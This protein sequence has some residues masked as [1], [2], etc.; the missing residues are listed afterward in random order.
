MKPK[1]RALIIGLDGATWR[2][3]TRLIRKGQLQTLK[4][5]VE[6][7]TSGNLQSTI[8]PWTIP[9][10]E[11]M[12][13][14]LNPGKIGFA[15]FTIRKG[16]NFIPYYFDHKV[17]HKN[18]WDMLSKNDKTVIV[19]NVP[20]IYSAYPING[21]MI[22]GFLTID[23][24][25]LTYPPSL[26]EKLNKV[27]GEYIP[28]IT[29]VMDLTLGDPQK[30]YQKEL[31]I[32]NIHH[33]TFTYLLLEYQ[34]DFGFIVYAEPDRVQHKFWG[35]WDRIKEIYRRLD[36]YLY[37]MLENVVT[38]DTVVFIVSDHGF[39]P[40]D[41]KILWINK[42]LMERGYLVLKRNI[43]RQILLRLLWVI[44]KLR[45]DKTVMAT[46][47]K[48]PPSVHK[49]LRESGKTLTSSGLI[50]QVDWSKT[51]AL[52]YGVYGEIFIN[53]PCDNPE[54]EITRNK[55]ILEL[56]KEF[57]D[58]KIFKKEEIYNGP[59]LSELPDLI[60]LVDDEHINA[61]SPNLEVDNLRLTKG[62][63]RLNGIFLAYGPGIK[64]GHKIENAKIYDIAPTIL[65]I[66]GLP[67]P[68]DM[69]GRVLTEI[70][71]EDSEFAKRKPKYVD[72][73]YYEKKG[74]DEKLKKAIKN[75]KLKGKI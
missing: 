75:L 39:G 1:T 74:E 48:F 56:K 63:H 22:G 7:G 70:F 28:D 41:K 61:V 2:I 6:N 27:T 17:R 54:Y 55:L 33:L 45:L 25:R 58:I 37:E 69:D 20:N 34:W 12:S 38:D 23:H 5:L 32:L 50:S 46:I 52:S 47:E 65:H 19:A 11:V 8:P 68:N 73:S 42:F 3:I 66:F 62:N 35:D 59:Y 16:T 26:K 71:E 30:V 4:H 14:G 29:T 21:V 36:N 15:T 67:I 24:S 64:K 43:R 31:E 10:W 72:P 53:I 44:K 51:K 13:T 18:I 40:G 57:G 60:I 9:A 49:I